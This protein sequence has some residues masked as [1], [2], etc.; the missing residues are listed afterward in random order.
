MST[1]CSAPLRKASVKRMPEVLGIDTSNYTTS[2]ALWRD[3]TVKQKKK[4]LPV[5]EGE[6]GLRQ[7]D[8]VFHHVRQLP[9]VLAALPLKGTSLSAVGV[10]TRPRSREGSYMPCFLA[11]AG[12]AKAI[13]MTAG[14]PL[15]EF[16][17]QQGH[18][19]AALYSAG[20][21]D[22]LKGRFLAFHVSGGTTEA[23]LAEPDETEFFHVEIVARSLDLKGGQA[24]DRVGRMLGLSFPAGP[25][26]E[27][28]ARKTTAASRS[29]PV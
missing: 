19:A 20:R 26:M 24:V 11:G 3:G 25:E 29:G 23:V 14:V 8:A 22:L 27:R 6:L 17:H 13:S 21:L 10:S 7:S 2:A 4:L 18:I 15:F 28:L 12:T 16:S 9:E 1:A 5:R